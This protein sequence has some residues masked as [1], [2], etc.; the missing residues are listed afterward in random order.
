[1]DNIYSKF[2][3]IG[4]QNK[5]ENIK[6]Y[7][8][9]RSNSM[10]FYSSFQARKLPSNLSE[11]IPYK[12]RKEGFTSSDMKVQMLEE[13]LRKLEDKNI[14]LTH[15]I[16]NR[17]NTN[18]E[19]TQFTN[20]QTI[21]V[22]PIVI[23]QPLLLSNNHLNKNINIAK[24][25]EI[26]NE[27]LKSRL[28]LNNYRGLQKQD[29]DE[30]NIPNE[31]L[32][33]SIFDRKKDNEARKEKEK[34]RKEI[35]RKT[36]EKLYLNDG[37]ISDL[38]QRKKAKKFVN[39]LDKEIYSPL[40]N[41]F[42]DYINNVNKNI[43]KQFEE[44]NILINQDIDKMEDDFNEIKNMIN[45]RLEDMEIK[46][47]S[48]FEKLKDVIKNV[49]GKKM[50]SAIENVFEG[51]NIDLNQAEDDYLVNEVFN[52]PK[53]I[54]E[55]KLKEEMNSI[56][57]ENLIRKKINEQMNYELEKK[58]EI[59]E[60]K[61]LKKM[62]MMEINREKQR[63][64]NLK[65]LNKLRYEVMH[66]NQN[67]YDNYNMKDMN[68]MNYMSPINYG[69]NDLFK[70]YLVKKIND[71]NRGP[72]INFAN[73]NNMSTDEL[74][75]YM[76][77]KN[78]GLNNINNMNNNNNYDQIL[79]FDF[80]NT[81]D[82]RLRNLVNN[83]KE[84]NKNNNNNNKINERKSMIK[85]SSNNN[86]SSKKITKNDNNINSKKSETKKSNKSKSSSTIKVDSKESKSKSDSSTSNSKSKSKSKSES[87][88]E[89]NNKNENKKEQSKDDNKDGNKDK[90]D[91]KEEDEDEENKEEEDEDDED[92][93]DNNEN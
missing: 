59:E 8:L 41:D 83:R 85:K 82:N 80:N 40:E 67:N 11:Y 14:Q 20:M 89:K 74:L 45:K 75:K 57:K 65:N 30:Q 84:N 47:K 25:Y 42:P 60:L 78:M 12:K 37:E 5:V 1:M 33:K 68:Y 64:E 7:G 90:E 32:Y 52:L 28:K 22:Q 3:G 93:D 72:P 10:P 87:T 13:K 86:K 21:P 34:E 18:N 92:E 61:H 63:R 19:N 66:G 88:K 69:I 71:S 56:E 38:S 70:I 44:D 9:L 35:K 2:L 81:N 58:R 6:N 26:N 48:N 27:I 23:Q 4:F 51:K 76:L 46:Q 16:T 36:L 91:E 54:K 39:K 77:F 49:G 17:N 24:S 29:Y 31:N 53:I 55:K 50:S 73:I 43:Q 62:K 79:N 15:S